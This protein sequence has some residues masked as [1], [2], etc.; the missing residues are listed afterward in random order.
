MPVGKAYPENPQILAMGE[1]QEGVKI[2]TGDRV[3]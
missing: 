1:C 2:E 3:L